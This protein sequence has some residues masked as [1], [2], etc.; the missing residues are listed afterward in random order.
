[1]SPGERC[2]VARGVGDCRQQVASGG[3]HDGRTQRQ[4]CPCKQ[5]QQQSAAMLLGPVDGAEI[6]LTP[7]F[8]WQ[9]NP[10]RSAQGERGGGIFTAAR[11][12]SQQRPACR[13]PAMPAGDGGGSGRGGGAPSGS[14]NQYSVSSEEMS[15][16]KMA[17]SYCAS[18][19]PSRGP[20]S[21]RGICTASHRPPPRTSPQS[22]AYNPLEPRYTDALLAEHKLCQPP[23]PPS[24]PFMCPCRRT[25]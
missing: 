3:V 23:P 18:T 13:P 11:Q 5:Q 17:S 9:E 8:D 14:V 10:R 15:L 1:M 19:R 22:A 12:G 4:S 7:T 2:A 21:G 25:Q 20:S 24:Q 6:V 16:V